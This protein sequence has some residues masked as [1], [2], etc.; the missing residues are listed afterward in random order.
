VDR[1]SAKWTS[2]AVSTSS[3]KFKP[4]PALSGINICA[5]KQV[6]ATL[7]AEQIG[8]PA[9]FQI[10]IDGGPTMN[11][12]A[13]RFTPAGSEDSSSF[14]WV[15]SV[16]P[17]EAND[18]HGFDVEWRSPTGKKTTLQSATVNLLYQRGTHKC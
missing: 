15:R 14:S 9:G 1:Q 18:H 8:A 16:S 12:G 3:T 11:P 7:S 6:T 10:R 5:A 17:F 2:S 13:V 4:I